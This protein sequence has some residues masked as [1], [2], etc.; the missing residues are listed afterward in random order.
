MLRGPARG[1]SIRTDEEATMA[2]GHLDY[3]YR[4]FVR[5]S[6]S[7]SLG[8]AT[9]CYS[10]SRRPWNIS[11]CPGKGDFFPE[12]VRNQAVP[13]ERDLPTGQHHDVVLIFVLAAGCQLC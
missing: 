12:V 1:L 2:K 7:F 6:Q 5:I 8:N 11:S 3:K 4:E 9:L 13:L 10:T